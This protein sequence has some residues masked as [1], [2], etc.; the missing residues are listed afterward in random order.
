LANHW[1]SVCSNTQ[2]HSASALQL[3]VKS[4]VPLK[5]EGV[6]PDGAGVGANGITGP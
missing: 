5:T 1:L 2:V 4:V 6:D 3:S